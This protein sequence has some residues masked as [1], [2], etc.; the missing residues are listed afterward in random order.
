MKITCLGKWGAYPE[1]ASA[2][3]SFL[4]EES[5]F[6]L[7]IDCGSGG[8]AGLQQVIPIQELDAVILSHYHHDH[9]ADIGC[10]QY[11]MM[12]QSLLVNRNS[13]LPI[14]GHEEGEHLFNT[15]TYKNFTNAVRISAN[16]LVHIGPWKVEF[17]PTIHPV[18]CLA[19]KFTG[20]N[21]QTRIVYTADTGWSDQLVNFAKGADLLVCEASL[22]NEQK[23]QVQGHM[24]AGEAGKLA[25]KAGARQ[26]VLTH[27]P[28][29]G[30]HRDLA[31]QASSVFDGKVQ[32]ARE[33]SSVEVG[34]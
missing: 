25:A 5:D 19:M 33:M 7:L 26:L 18:Y 16:Q 17:C 28:H 11:S 21:G 1:A 23:G 27:L 20:S 31:S 22:Y 4:L 9:V 12:I 29:Y 8:L 15:L 6:R 30:V 3:S 34:N 32:I 10:L 2:T 13:P 24:T 14:Y